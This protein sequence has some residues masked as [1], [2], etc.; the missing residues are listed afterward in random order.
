MQNCLRGAKRTGGAGWQQCGVPDNQPLSPEPPTY[1]ARFEPQ[2]S[3]SA[4]PSQKPPGFGGYPQRIA[5]EVEETVNEEGLLGWM[6]FEGQDDLQAKK[7]GNQEMGLF[8]TWSPQGMT[9]HA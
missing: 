4:C 9:G 5:R 8:P 3:S 1:R 7:P 6:I 2:W